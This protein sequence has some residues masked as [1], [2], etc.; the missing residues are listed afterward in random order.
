M[1]K[2][3]LIG[4]T[5]TLFASGA[6]ATP[7]FAD[8]FESG[9]GNW[10]V[11]PSSGIVTLDIDA[12]HAHSPT[13]SFRAADSTTPYAAY[14]NFGSTLDALHAEVYL[15]D[16]A[17][18]NVN[19][20]S[21]SRPVNIMLSLWGSTSSSGGYHQLGVFGGG[22]GNA[23]EYRIRTRDNG[24]DTYLA[25][26]SPYNL[27]TQG[28]TK[29]AI[30]ADA[31]AGAEVRYYIND[32]LVGTSHRQGTLANIRLGVNFGSSYDPI[33]YDDVLVTPEPGALA[34]LGLGGLVFLRRRRAA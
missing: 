1:R 29:L 23:N 20:Q 21:P 8:D 4:V 11:W 10:T 5:L 2:Y 17:E 26:P 15:W 30:D 31:G 33:W 27:R 19:G 7:Y 12:N 16:D 28:F 13:H 9:S 25:V 14:H 3:L 24:V 22:S 6:S 18:D 32:H 34:L